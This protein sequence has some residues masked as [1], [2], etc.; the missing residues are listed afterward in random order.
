MFGELL[1]FKQFLA[2]I[3]IRKERLEYNLSK[4]RKEIIRKC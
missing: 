2:V 4:K 1:V 3:S